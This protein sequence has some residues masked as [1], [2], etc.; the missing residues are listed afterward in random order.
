MSARLRRN[1]HAVAQ[2]ERQPLGGKTV[3]RNLKHGRPRGVETMGEV[4][5][6]EVDGPRL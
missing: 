1:R 5:E 3:K 6:K 2:S 4:A